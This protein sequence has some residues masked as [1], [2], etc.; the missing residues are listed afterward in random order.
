M[1][2]MPTEPGKRAWAQLKLQSAGWWVWTHGA[3]GGEEMAELWEEL[4]GQVK[5]EQSP[6]PFRQLTVP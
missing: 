2:G 5:R 4:T 3:S 6:S 1:A